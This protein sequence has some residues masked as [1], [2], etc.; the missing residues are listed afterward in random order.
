[1]YE[2]AFRGLF[3]CFL[4]PNA[5]ALQGAMADS[6]IEFNPAESGSFEHTNW[7]TVKEAGSPGSPS[8]DA[9]RTSIY[10]IYWNPI[11]F[12]IRRMGQGPEDAQDLAQEFFTRVF[13]KNY[14]QS[15]DREKGKFRTFLL[16]MLKRFLADQWDRAT[17]QKR[18]GGKQIISLEGQDTEIRHKMEP[19]DDETPE[20]AFERRWAASL[21]D[22][23]LKQLEAEQ[24][25]AGKTDTFTELK[26]FLTNEQEGSCA[27]AAQRVRVCV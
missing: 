6:E 12:Y 4:R 13:E 10:K 19:A 26:P 20:T 16:T 2:K 25:S 23:V 22:Q 3:P 7:F 14:L 11:Y 1:L 18:G 5:I 21:L 8:N 15:A 27:D 17:R 24:A 9:A